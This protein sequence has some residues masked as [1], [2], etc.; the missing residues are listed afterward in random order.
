S[1]TAPIKV[2]VTSGRI[3]PRPP[4]M[5]ECLAVAK[6]V[7][8]G[9]PEFAVPA[10]RALAERHHVVGVVTQPDRP[11]GRGQR[12]VEA[13]VKQFSR[14]AGLPVIQPQ[15]LREPEALAQLT[16]WAP[17]IIIVAAFGQ[18]LK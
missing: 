9:T 13:P 17:E 3:S 7:F 5:L 11:A 6:I 8:M 10:L 16:A 14:Q 15:R 2:T 12:V 18:I 4:G 1:L